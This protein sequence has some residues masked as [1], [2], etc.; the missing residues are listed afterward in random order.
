VPEEP[1]RVGEEPAGQGDRVSLVVV[2]LLDLA[3]CIDLQYPR[4]RHGE[5]DWRVRGH[6]ELAALCD[7]VGDP[8]EQGE[9]AARRERRFRLVEQI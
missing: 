2:D 6:H 4:T 8:G 5:Q 7:Q 9:A 3:V 1:L